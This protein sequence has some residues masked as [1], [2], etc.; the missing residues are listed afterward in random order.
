MSVQRDLEILSITINDLD[1]LHRSYMP[2]IINGGL[3]LPT[4]STYPLNYELFILLR[5]IDHPERLSINGKV[6]WI[7]P[8]NSENYRVQG[9]GI[10]FYNDTNSTIKFK[11]ENLLS[12]HLNCM[13]ATYTM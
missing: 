12:T 5:L 2:F 8:G 1:E 4:K 13:Q 7:T 11:I 9:V 3:F 10:Q 6:I